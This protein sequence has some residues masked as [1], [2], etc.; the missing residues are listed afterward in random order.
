MHERAA[1]TVPLAVRADGQRAEGKKGVVADVAPG[2]QVVAVY[3][4]RGGDRDQG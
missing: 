1:D 4:V 2:R 3:L